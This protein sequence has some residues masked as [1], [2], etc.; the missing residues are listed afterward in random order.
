MIILLQRAP[1]PSWQAGLVSVRRLVRCSMVLRFTSRC[2]RAPSPLLTPAFSN[3]SWF[4]RKAGLGRNV[5][6][7]VSWTPPVEPRWL[8]K[9]HY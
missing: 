8:P 6:T 7:V 9:H 5:I 3:I 4:S 2:Q 1:L